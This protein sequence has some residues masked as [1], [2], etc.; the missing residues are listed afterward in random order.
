MRVSSI[1]LSLILIL[2]VRNAFMSTGQSTGGS[3]P[4]ANQTTTAA[5]PPPAN[6]TT[7][8]TAG[9]ELRIAVPVSTYKEF[10]SITTDPLTK[11]QKIDGFSIQVFEAVVNTALSS[12][13]DYKLIP[14]SKPDGTFNGSFD[15]MLK[16][17]NNQEYDGA[18]GDTTIRYDR[19][20]W[21]DFTLPYSD[22][23]ITMMVS[24]KQQHHKSTGIKLMPLI[25]GLV[26]AA[27]AFCFVS[28]LIFWF[29]EFRNDKSRQSQAPLGTNPP[30]QRSNNDDYWRRETL[31]AIIHTRLVIV[32]CFL[33]LLFL[34]SCYAAS[35]TSLLTA[36]RQRS[37][38]KTIDELIRRRENVGNQK[39]SFVPRLL[40]QR[41]FSESQIL[42]YDTEQEMIDM[43]AKGTVA[44]VIDETPY[45]KV[46]LSKNCNKGYNLVPSFDLHAEGF[47]FAFQK[48]S[49]LVQ[50]MSKGILKLLDNGVLADIQQRTI[51][52]L[53]ACENE[54][55]V[56]DLD[57]N[58]LDFDTLW[59]L[60]AGA[61][62][63]IIL[64]IILYMV[65]L[66]TTCDTVRRRVAFPCYLLPRYQERKS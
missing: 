8:A 55:D 36:Q 6:Q 11:K 23:G 65:Y 45:L 22:T 46:F 13:F 9:R 35:L 14:F 43:L 60:F 20:Q 62:G 57:A 41:G 10:V 61:I 25:K 29:V 3:P 34:T 2:I 63:V 56:A 59:I 42:T 64:V 47:G 49:T 4:P 17:V 12:P 50:D 21:V 15:D 30:G 40:I 53:E 44:A 32:L 7:T 28:A 5:A 33:V 39:G 16:A 38:V 37:S 31:R 1:S 54:P 24:T 51:G 27:L 52:N 19:S 58:V 48:G 18:V 26:S 66:G